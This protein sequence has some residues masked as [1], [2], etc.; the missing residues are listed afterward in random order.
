MFKKK[1]IFSLLALIFVAAVGVGTTVAFITHIAG[2]IDNTFIIGEI[3]MTLRETAGAKYQLIPGNTYKKD[4]TVTV[5]SGSQDCFVFIKITKQNDT[6][7]Y[8]SYMI[9][10]GWHP[11]TNYD[12]VYYRTVEN[13]TEDAVFPVL[14]DNLITVKDTVTK[15]EIQNITSSPKL[16]FTAYAIQSS[17]IDDAKTAY[18][19]ILS[20]E[21]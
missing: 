14:K 11:L 18:D 13:I 1:L 10:D 16:I 19:A 12:G 4:P 3:D 7:R 20:A 15:E 21:E 6:D 17:G 5:K 9:S 8:I 2:P